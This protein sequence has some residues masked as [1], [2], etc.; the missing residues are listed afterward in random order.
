VAAIGFVLIGALAVCYI[1]GVISAFAS[2][3]GIL[4][5]LI[6]LAVPFPD[7]LIVANAPEEIRDLVYRRP[8]PW[9]F[10]MVAIA[11]LTS[12]LILVVPGWL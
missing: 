3:T 12:W 1:G 8:L 6:P 10:A 4:G 5:A 9:G 2:A 11:P 7:S